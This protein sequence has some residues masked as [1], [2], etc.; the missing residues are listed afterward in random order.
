MP[1]LLTD[2]KTF[3]G[4]RHVLHLLP[5]PS[6]HTEVPWYGVLR[7]ESSSSESFLGL[8]HC[9]LVRNTHRTTGSRFD[10]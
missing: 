4:T 10:V 6:R 7:C 3:E 8:C 2:S 9:R 5:H 1:P